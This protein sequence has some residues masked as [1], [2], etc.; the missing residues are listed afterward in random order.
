MKQRV[1]NPENIIS[2]PE[3]ILNHLDKPFSQRALPSHPLRTFCRSFARRV[4]RNGFAD[5]QLWRNARHAGAG[6]SF[7]IFTGRC[8]S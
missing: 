3:P 7:R 2:I 8:A 1:V 4:W 5:K 6:F